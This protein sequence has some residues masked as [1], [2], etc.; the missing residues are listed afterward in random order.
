VA[1]PLLGF[2]TVLIAALAEVVTPV[3]STAQTSTPIPDLERIVRDGMREDVIPGV[4][5]VLVDSGR[6]VFSEGFGVADLATGRAVSPDSTL[7]RLGSVTKVLTS[8]GILRLVERGAI[9]LDTPVRDVAPLPVLTTGAGEPIRVR[10]LLSHTAGF[11]QSGLGRHAPSAAERQSLRAFLAEYLVP[12][13][14]PGVVATYDTYGMSLAGYVLEAVSGIPYA[15]FMRAEV[16]EPLGMR[17]TFIEAPPE[18][19]ARLAVGYGLEGG[20]PVVQPYEWYVTLPTSS[21]D[22]T[23]SDVARLMIALLGDGSARGNR[24]LRPETVA[25][26]QEGGFTEAVPPFWDGWWLGKA[27]GHPVL[28][29]GGVMRGYTTQLL[30]L[31]DRG[32]GLF[33]AY[34]RD[35]ETGPPPRLRGRLTDAFL[36][37]FLTEATP[38]AAE[39]ITLPTEGFAG[40]WVGTLGCFT[41]RSGEGWPVQTERIESAG[42]GALRFRGARWLAVDSV[43]FRREDSGATLRFARDDAG[44]MRYAN[45]GQDGFERLDARLIERVTTRMGPGREP[46]AL[47]TELAKA[48]AY[49]GRAQAM[50]ALAA[51]PPALQPA[52]TFLFRPAGAEGGEPMR[53]ELQAV[54]GG[55]AGWVQSRPDRPRRTVSR[56][57]VGGNEVWIVV[58]VPGGELDIRLVVAGATVT[59]TIREGLE[60]TPI[61]GQF[62]ASRE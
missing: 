37:A 60:E 27:R 41:C 48:T 19:K 9:S 52:G 62:V 15:D 14:P 13:R 38:E 39:S 59:G 33:V 11:D 40:W 5:V 22:A 25:A 53:V 36:Q 17:Q 56:V 18:V 55:F 16:F 47:Q 31:P 32:A 20:E 10:H 49:D 51:R 58:D 43:T 1:R 2:M 8:L 46:E 61:N 24:L 23:A 29:H 30:L 42:P 44:V 6:V 12:I 35:P 21:A 34:N 26:L 4:V 50:A 45:A 54:D 3:S 57:I 7:F 28:Y